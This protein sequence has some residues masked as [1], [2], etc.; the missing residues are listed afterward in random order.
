MKKHILTAVLT[1]AA[2][3]S[4]ASVIDC[5]LHETEEMRSPRMALYSHDG[6]IHSATLV[7][8]TDYGDTLPYLFSCS[9]NCV[10]DMAGEDY[11]YSLGIEPGPDAPRTVKLITESKSSD[12]RSVDTLTVENCEE[13]RNDE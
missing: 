8:T 12:F 6:V 10:M 2:S 9:I 5:T 7:Y 4:L 13:V 11:R 1:I 3:P